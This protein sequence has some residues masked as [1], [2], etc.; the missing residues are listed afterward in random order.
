MYD[1]VS[2]KS[3]ALRRCL[4]VDWKDLLAVDLNSVLGHAVGGALI[5]LP[6][7]IDDLSSANRLVCFSTLL[8][9]RYQGS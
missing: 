4:I 5:I 7:N 9:S 2:L 1:A 6:Y 3:N 8:L